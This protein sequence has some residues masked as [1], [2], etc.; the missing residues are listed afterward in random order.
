MV[1][2]EDECELVTKK[3]A[4]FQYSGLKKLSRGMIGNDSGQPWFLFW[5][6]N[7]LEVCNQNL[8][9]L[10][11]DMKTK[12]CAYLR[13]CHNSVE[14]GFAG[15][16]GMQ[17]HVASTYA[18]VMAIVNVG[19]KEAY[20]IIDRPKMR[21]YLNRI[22][23]NMDVNYEQSEPYNTWIFKHKETKEQYKH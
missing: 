9:N 2:E 4:L 10:D 6:T 21:A 5:L 17:T 20:D 8:M 18:A 11:D 13:T 14:G 15:A 16:P 19:T 1:D 7:A 3:H 22:K 23:N 12:C